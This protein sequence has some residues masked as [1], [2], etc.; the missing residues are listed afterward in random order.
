MAHFGYCCKVGAVSF[1]GRMPIGQGDQDIPLQIL[2]S[3]LIAR[4]PVGEADA[5]IAKPL[6]VDDFSQVFNISGRLPALPC[7]VNL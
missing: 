2:K 4:C 1:D 6:Q 7:G 5:D 3:R